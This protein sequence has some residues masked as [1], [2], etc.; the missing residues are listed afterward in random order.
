MYD[1]WYEYVKLIYE[2][3]EKLLYMDTD[4]IIVYIKTDDIYADIQKD[5]EMD[6]LI[7]AVNYTDH[8]QKRKMRK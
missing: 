7:Q 5:F 1:F 8:Y 4:S 2:E 6:L 3:K